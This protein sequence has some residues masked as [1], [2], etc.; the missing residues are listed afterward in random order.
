MRFVGRVCVFVGVLLF[1]WLQVLYRQIPVNTT[2]GIYP[3]RQRHPNAVIPVVISCIYEGSPS[4]D[5]MRMR[6]DVS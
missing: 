2:C 3:N 6:V 5:R 4:V 1:V